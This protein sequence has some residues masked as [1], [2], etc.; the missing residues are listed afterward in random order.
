MY[1]VERDGQLILM[2]G[3]GEKSSQAR[4]IAQ[5]RQTAKEL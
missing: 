1:Y 2:L 3:G 5:A 4:D